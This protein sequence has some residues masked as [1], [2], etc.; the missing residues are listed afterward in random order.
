MQWNQTQA[1]ESTQKDFNPSFLQLK[2]PI[3]I[4]R[5]FVNN[6]TRE[7]AQQK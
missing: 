6:P 4:E 3:Y 2:L 1:P 5:L 7:S